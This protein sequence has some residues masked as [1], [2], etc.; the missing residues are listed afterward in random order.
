MERDEIIDSIVKLVNAEKHAAPAI[1]DQLRLVRERLEEAL[2][3]TVKP[4]EAAR[5]LGVSQPALK[6]WLD[7]GDIATVLTR[8]GR[9]EIP[10]RELIALVAEA[11][12]ARRHGRERPLSAVVRERWRQAN[13]DAEFDRLIPPRRTTR[14]HRDPERISQ[15]YHRLVAERLTPELV[16]EAKARL[17]RW[18]RSGRIDRKWA[19]DWWALLDQ[20]LSRI[21]KEISSGSQRARDL[22]QTSPFA[23]ALTEQER[24]RLLASAN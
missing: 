6:R 22:R 12:T 2:G 9:R 7:K 19:D 17:R 8:R 20:P 23:G 18:E 24:R 10:V 3:E 1:R 14:T 4:A 11:E 15:A 5:L 16:E 13:E 21:A